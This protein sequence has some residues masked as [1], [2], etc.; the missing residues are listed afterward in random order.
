ME[1]KHELVI[2]IVNEGYSEAVMQSAREV[3]VT[4]GT[5]I[6]AR[7]TT[8]K[9]VEAIFQITVHPEKELV[10]MIIE[11][12]IKEKVLHAL[13]KSVGLQTAGQGIAFSLPV[14]NVVG[15]SSI[16]QNTSKKQEN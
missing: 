3:G 11:S 2:C 8:P 14:T 5:V 1:N 12:Q 16:E 15:L 10:L 6:N 9:D 7:G 13:Y 4:G